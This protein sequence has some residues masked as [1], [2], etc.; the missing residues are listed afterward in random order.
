[1]HERRGTAAELHALDVLA[2]PSTVWR[3]APTAPTI[4]L[5][6]SQRDDVVDDAE[7]GRR[8]LQR[9]RRRSGGGVVLVDPDDSVW[10]DV[11]VP[12]GDP[13]WD[14]D[15]SRA[16]H[17]LGDAWVDALAS[18]GVGAVSHRGEP[19][20]R[21]AGRVVCFAGLGSGEVT[22]DGRKVVGISQRRDRRGARFQCVVHRRWDPDSVLSL[23][24]PGAGDDRAREKI[25]ER[26]TQ[27]VAPVERLDE[28]FDA[29][30]SIL[31]H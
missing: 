18:V 4:V 20:C 10:V 13:R 12:V 19:V 8:G 16:F 6:S 5:G 29:L 23:L 28:A 27:H 11:V 7:L 30:V 22:V 15:V 14:D 3:M 1:M 25:R 9:C 31:T 2:E 21:G 17:W 24:G 26:L